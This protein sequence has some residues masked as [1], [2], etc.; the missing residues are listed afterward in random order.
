M[1]RY[2]LKDNFRGFAKVFLPKKNERAKRNNN[3]ANIITGLRSGFF[4]Y[5][6]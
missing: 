6:C 5:Q 1:A 4:I 2:V 3:P